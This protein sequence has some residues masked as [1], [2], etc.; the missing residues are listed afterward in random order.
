VRLAVCECEHVSSNNMEVDGTVL[1][2]QG[3]RPC[4]VLLEDEKA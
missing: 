2:T 1:L 3:I 4:A